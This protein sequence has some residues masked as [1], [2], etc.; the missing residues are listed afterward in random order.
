MTPTPE[1][2][3]RSLFDSKAV[4]QSA[5]IRRN[6]RDVERIVGRPAFLAELHRRGFSAVENASQIVIFF[7]RE[8]ICRVA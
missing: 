6:V 7:N 2:F 4:Q 8:P 5:A 1:S 3:F